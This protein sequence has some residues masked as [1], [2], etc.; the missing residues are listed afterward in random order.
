FHFV[1]HSSPEDDEANYATL[2]I[3]LN[4]RCISHP[5]HDG[6]WGTTSYKVNWEKLLETE[7]LLVPS[8][9]CFADIPFEALSLHISK[10]GKFGV[11]LP[12][13]LLVKYGTRPVY[14]FPISKQ[15]ALSVHGVSLLRDIESTVKG[16][17]EQL[18]GEEAEDTVSREMG[19]TP[20]SPESAILALDS[21]VFKDFIAFVKPFNV[22]LPHSDPSNFYMEREWRKYGNMKFSQNEVSRLVVARGFEERAKADFPDYGERIFGV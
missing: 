4:G 8:V 1:G 14:Y 7:E 13:S 5:P 16:F 3:V 15:D 10:Y 2:K 6:T 12:L 9:T 22:D 19:S 18:I 11:A 21:M 17:K 20:D